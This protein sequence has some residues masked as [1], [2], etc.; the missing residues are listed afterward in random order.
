[1][2]GTGQLFEALVKY[3]QSLSAQE[4]AV[5]GESLTVQVLPLPIAG[6][7]DYR[8]LA[9]K[10]LQQLPSEDF[11][12]VA[13]SFSGGI[14]AC[15][16]QQAVLHLKGI[17]FVASFLSGPKKLIAYLASH[18][19]LR[20]LAHLPFSN[21]VYRLL[22]LGKEATPGQIALFRSALNTVPANVLKLRLRAIAEAEY[23]GFTSDVPAVY[24]AAANDRLVPAI[25]KREF[26]QAY[27]DIAFAEIA[28]PHFI[29]QANPKDSAATIL[30]AANLIKNR[31][32]C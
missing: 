18:L 5:Q 32:C 4:Q 22:M 1:M 21:A 16:S 15:L 28:G 20:H 14:A 6:A 27:S 26:V 25:K 11:I 31:N 24:I 30:K 17:I 3:F 8:N 9:A 2:D 29:L 7:Q 19:P 13:E 12:L 23:D 10:V